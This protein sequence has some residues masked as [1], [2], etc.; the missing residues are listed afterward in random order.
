M[1]TV[2]NGSSPSITFSDSTTQTT[3]AVVGGKV[4]YSIMPTGSVLQ[5]VNATYLTSTSTSSTTY[6]DTGLTATITPLFSTSKILILVNQNFRLTSTTDAGG[7]INIVRNSTVIFTPADLLQN[8]TYAGGVASIELRGNLCINYLDS[9]ATT[10]ATT[11]KTQQAGY[12]SKTVYTQS[13]NNIST[14][15]L[16]EI[17][18]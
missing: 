13:Q 15:T 17:A 12:T 10:S 2:I 18:A 14:I 3:S 4:P 6:T 1:T 9:P 16:M 11:Y 8:Y 7:S 5:V